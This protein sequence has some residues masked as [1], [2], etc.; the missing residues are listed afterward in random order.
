MDITESRWRALARS[1]PWRWG[2]V[3][4]VRASDGPWGEVEAWIRRPGLMRVETGGETYVVVDRPP[5][6]AVFGVREDGQPFS[7]RHTPAPATSVTPAL[8]ADGLVAARPDSAGEEYDP[9]CGCCPLLRCEVAARHEAE[10]GGRAADPVGLAEIFEV[11]LDVET[12]I[13]VAVHPA[14]GSTS[15]GHS[16]RVLAVDEDYPDELFEE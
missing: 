10:T 2:S 4:L 15:S 6:V 8:D 12:G 14:P 3:H 11:A 16:V 7:S 1:S 9:R 5:E 13:C